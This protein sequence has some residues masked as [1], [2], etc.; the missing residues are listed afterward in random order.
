MSRTVVTD[1]PKKPHNDYEL[2]LN[3]KQ[4]LT[5]GLIEDLGLTDEEIEAVAKF[6]G[7]VTNKTCRRFRSENNKN[8]SL[9]FCLIRPSTDKKDLV[10]EETVLGW[11]I[12]IPES[13]AKRPDIKW[14]VTKDWFE[15]YGTE[16]T[17]ESE[18]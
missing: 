10:S 6:E 4:R 14:V 7:G 8:P 17:D 16:I 18:S 3:R 2:R 5:V 13:D 15:K 11:G 12:S 9:H 1:D